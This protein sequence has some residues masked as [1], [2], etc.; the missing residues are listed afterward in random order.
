[1]DSLRA[2]VQEPGEWF[3]SSLRRSGSP[4]AAG[5]HVDWS[6]EA[7]LRKSSS[8]DPLVSTTLGAQTLSYVNSDQSD[9][10]SVTV[11]EIVA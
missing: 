9:L 2:R 11:L 7:W 8:D 4:F 3:L 5:S 6:P 10:G 1:M